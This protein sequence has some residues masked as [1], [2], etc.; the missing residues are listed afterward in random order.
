MVLAHQVEVLIPTL[1][2]LPVAVMATDRNGV[3]CWANACLSALTGY[4]ADE[5]VG[6]DAEMLL[7][8]ETERSHREALEHVVASGESWRGE[9]AGKRKNGEVYAIVQSIAP[10]QDAAGK[11]TH[12]LWTALEVQDGRVA[13]ELRRCREELVIL[14]GNSPTPY[15]SLDAGGCLI[16]VNE[17]WLQGLGYSR[18][19]VLGR[20]FSDFLTPGQADFYREWF[21]QFKERGWVRDVEFSLVKKDGSYI[22]AAFDG[23]IGRDSDGQFRQTHCVWRDVTERKQAERRYRDILEGAAEGMYRTTLQGKSLSANPALAAILGYDSAQALISAITDTTHQLWLD[24]NERSRLFELLER[25]EVVRGYDCQFKRKDGTGIWVSLN[26][27]KVR[28]PGDEAAYCEGFIEDITERKDAE[29]RLR[30]Q[31]ERFQRIIDNTD[32][33]YFRIGADGC[34]EDVNPAWLR[35]YGFTRREDVI[36]QHF[37][38]VQVPEDV[39]KAKETVRS[40]MQGESA[41]SGEFSRLRRDGTIGHHS[42]SANPVLDGDRVIGIEGFL[43]DISDKIKAEQERRHTE[44]RYRSLFDCMHE[45]AALHKLI[46]ANGIP[47]N[48][49]LLDVNRRFE[50]ILGVKREQVVNKAA[51]DVYGS[52]DAPYLKE[53]AAVVETGTPVQFETYYPPMDRYFSISVAPMGGDLFATIFFDITE[54]KRA[55]AELE[56][57]SRMVNMAL[58]AGRSGAWEL[59]LETGRVFWTEECCRLF[60]QEPHFAPT[61]NAFYALI[62]PEDRAVVQHAIEHCSPTFSI[63]FRIVLPDG[64]H[65]ME[66]RGEVIYDSA[67]KPVRIVGITSDISEQKRFEEAMG[68]LVTAIEHAEEQ[69]LVTDDKGNIRYLNPAFERVT[70]YSKSEALGQ[71]PRILKS[72][73]HDREFYAQLWATLKAGTVWRG[74]LTNKKK[75]GALYEEDATIS[76]IRDG[77]GRITGFVAV[78]RDVTEQLQLERQFLQAQKLQS[79]G[80]LAGGVAHDF[81]NLL[82]VINGY[83]DFLLAD[84]DR[85]GPLWSSADE[86]RKA[87]ERAASLTR[88]LLTFSRKQIIEPKTL[89]L[90]TTIRESER[91]LQ[92][93]I[94]EDVTLTTTLDP[95][96]G[97]V[98]A[99]PEQI[100]QVIM[101]LVVNARDAMPDGGRL[102]ISTVNIDITEAGAS[103]HQDAKRGPHVMMSV[104]DTGTGIDEKTRQH[105]FEPFFTTKKGDKGTGLGLSTVYGIMRQSGGW[106]DVSSDRGGGTSFKLYFP[107]IDGRV[108]EQPRETIRS[109]GTHGGETILVVEDQEAVRRLTKAMLKVYGYRILEA[110]NATEALDVAQEYSGEIHLLLTDVVLP[111]L[112][113][114]ELSERLRTLR[115]KLKV[116][117]TSGYTADIIAHRGVLGYGLAYIPKPFSPETLAAKVRKLLSEPDTPE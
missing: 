3:I 99:D 48:Y 64:I 43:V 101:N 53:Y 103:I 57:M 89:D 104:T 86:I 55:T 95:S 63:P 116:L 38:T 59:N 100:H 23:N 11:T 112:N 98:M 58:R 9:C 18:E 26:I 106:I 102:D 51:T 114:K 29:T 110:A 42:F 30:T 109:T 71:N 2:S 80:R 5:I 16:A 68:S 75:N 20:R 85:T 105:L 76:P 117:F 12:L 79:V 70:G 4:A 94:G 111:G 65:W 19:E 7:S 25:Q 91:M 96:L 67:G 92:R 69:I 66:R 47:V 88:Q 49:I 40:L 10:I 13:D 61:L 31:H 90:N 54:R 14:N 82:T 6:Q 33:G 34:Y 73:M 78:K 56:R 84:L 36:G 87:G 107:R 21:L 62:H 28:G 46:D 39:P 97:Q 50:E 17:A 93:L 15:Q 44:Q 22:D 81:N 74:R 60:G 52:A 77:S 83:A 108:V 1:A 113:G 45:G 27:R 72:G 115:P 41:K 37:S 35:M 24:P 8:G 32:A